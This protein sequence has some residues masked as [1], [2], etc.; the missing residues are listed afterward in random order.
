MISP[1]PQV[2]L[3]YE[4]DLMKGWRVQDECD[5]GIMACMI[6][7]TVHLPSHLKQPLRREN[8]TE[9]KNTICQNH[10]FDV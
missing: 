1:C 4:E 10:V 8:D 3:E 7:R 6:S 5:R 2:A 9:C